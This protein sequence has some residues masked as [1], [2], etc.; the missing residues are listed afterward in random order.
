VRVLAFGTYDR[1]YPRNAQVLSA[2]RGAGAEVVEQ[3][4][5]A[6]DPQTNWSLGARQAL[7][8]ARAELSLLRAPDL[9][10]DVVLVGYPGH[11]DLLAARRAAR[12]RPVV[13]NPLVSLHDTLVGDRG[14]FRPGSPAARLLERVDRFAFR[15]ADLVVADTEAHAAWI[16][17]RFDLPHDRVA[18]CLVGAED[19]LFVPGGA[20][21]DR[22]ASFHVLFVGKLIP[23]HGIDVVL[24]AA[25]L[26]PG[27]AFHVVGTGQL[28]LLL[29]GRPDNVA[30]TPWLDPSALP[31]AYRGAGCALGIFAP[32]AKASRVIPNKVFQALACGAVVV[33]GDT[34]A[35]RELLTD[36]LDSL[37]VPAGDPEG[38]ARA[39]QHLA[40]D[41]SLRARL[42]A[43]G[44]ETYERHA[45]EAVLGRRW[46]GLL[47]R[48]AAGR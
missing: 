3:H 26:L 7:R 39:I 6:W 2:L 17:D 45:S 10:A 19:R 40:G 25:R 47:E 1:A 29:A 44:R 34:P 33:T 27:V 24:A 36:G 14:R 41:P 42:G 23:L 16:R 11:F 30:W 35:A 8:V 4:R 38:L 21:T 5:A 48:V 31:D 43:A 12:G 22:G 13:F 9:A 18:V 32:T 37:L 46:L 28:D 15:S 20:G